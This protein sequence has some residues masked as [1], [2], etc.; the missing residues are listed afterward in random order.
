MTTLSI[1]TLRTMHSGI[2]QLPDVL[3]S[4]I[5]SF[6][7]IKSYHV[8][9]GVCSRFRILQSK[10]ESY[11]SRRLTLTTRLWER[12]CTTEQSVVDCLSRY[13]RS[14]HLK[15]EP[16]FAIDGSISSEWRHVRRALRA[17]RASETLEYVRDHFSK[18]RTIEICDYFRT[19]ETLEGF[20]R[21]NATNNI[22]M[23]VRLIMLDAA[24]SLGDVASEMAQR[25]L[26]FLPRILQAAADSRGRVR[27][28][29][30]DCGRPHFWA[31]GDILLNHC[32]PIERVAIERVS[33]KQCLVSS[34][35]G[36]HSMDALEELEMLP[37]SSIRSLQFLQNNDRLRMLRISTTQ[38][39]SEPRLGRAECVL[40]G[41][42]HLE[43]L[44]DQHCRQN[45]EWW[46]MIGDLKMP[47]IER[48]SVEMKGTD[49]TELGLLCEDDYVLSKLV[50]VVDA[51][52]TISRI[53][54]FA[55]D[56]GDHAQSLRNLQSDLIF[57]MNLS[58]GL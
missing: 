12:L 7:P 35:L 26:L 40:S 53:S 31:N 11:H 27:H 17:E 8:I 13:R 50:H 14:V 45:E 28:L 33:M 18:L 3:I 15:I 43:L 34:G 19:I 21:F 30:F 25:G 46:T 47:N 41:L 4:N 57:A 49:S 32:S 29:I 51:N 16:V 36:C 22:P 6:L 38:M 39:I 48:L 9:S 52:R 1:P 56:E 24:G 20:P 44:I 5:L 58:T 42:V 10:A 37:L 23:T 55:K 2:L 54:V